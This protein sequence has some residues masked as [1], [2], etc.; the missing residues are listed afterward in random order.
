MK[1][2]TV[3][4]NTSQ[5]T[6][7]QSVPLMSQS[8]WHRLFPH[9]TEGELR[10]HSQVKWLTQGQP[11]RERS[12]GAGNQLP[13]SLPLAL[14]FSQSSHFTMFQSHLFQELL[15][16][17]IRDSLPLHKSS[18]S[19]VLQN[20]VHWIVTRLGLKWDFQSVQRNSKCTY[21][22]LKCCHY[23]F[24]LKKGVCSVTN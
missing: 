24:C 10:Q 6:G 12:C 8:E 19:T 1:S 11:E 18:L 9:F 16:K 15:T 3:S 23:C 22:K 21:Q 20:H 5:P 13:P 4:K 7:Y 17:L 2:E 14:T